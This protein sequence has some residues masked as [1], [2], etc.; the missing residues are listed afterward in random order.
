MTV[1]DENPA[2]SVMSDALGYVEDEVEQVLDLDIDGAVEIHV[3]GFVTERDDRHEQ[4]VATS[5][6]SG[7]LAD[8]PDEEVVDIERQVR[9]MV[10]NRADGKHDDGLCFSNFAQF[11]P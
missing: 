9:P 7:F 10:F 5:A 3:M 6:A 2:E 11:G 4:D 8:L 1:G